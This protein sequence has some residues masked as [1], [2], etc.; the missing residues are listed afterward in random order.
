MAAA[1]HF[2]KHL[3]LSRPL[4]MRIS[5]SPLSVSSS[6]PFLFKHHHKVSSHHHCSSS[7]AAPPHKSSSTPYLSVL[8]HCSKDNAVIILTYFPSCRTRIVMLPKY[9]TSTCFCYYKDVLGDALL[10]FGATSVSID[11]NDHV[12][13]TIDEV[14]LFMPLVLS[15]HL[16]LEP[17]KDDDNL[18]II[19]MITIIVKANMNDDI[20]KVDKRGEVVMKGMECDLQPAAKKY[21]SLFYFASGLGT[22]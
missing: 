17:D 19:N 11:Q 9:L 7:S 2:I 3:T 1:W 12:A 4:I 15:F 14:L 8:I 13:Q 20:E 5:P 22:E 18:K 6:L 10:C 21:S 16:F